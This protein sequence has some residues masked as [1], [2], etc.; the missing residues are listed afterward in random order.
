M[1]VIT[2]IKSQKNQKRVNIFIDNKFSFGLDLENFVK[3]NLKV[4]QELDEVQIQLI[5]DSGEQQKIFDKVLRFV[6]VRPRSE[7][8]IKDYFKRKRINESIHRYM[9]KRL[10]SLELL[11]DAKFAKWWVD[12]RSVNRSKRMLHN[13]LRIKGVSKDIIDNVLNEV[14]IDEL[15]IAK[16]LINKKLYKFQR[17]DEKV[18]KQKIAQYLIGKGFDWNIIQDVLK[19]ILGDK[20]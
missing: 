1:A 19:S 3:F 15:K 4:D 11:D 2:S 5:K 12:F 13:E 6:M 18:E 8:E 14:K 9:I 10:K 20:I 17:Y 7:K 16:N